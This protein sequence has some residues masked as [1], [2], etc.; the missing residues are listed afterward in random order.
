MEGTISI[1]PPTDTPVLTFSRISG[2]HSSLLIDLNPED[3]LEPEIARARK[4]S[5]SRFEEIPREWTRRYAI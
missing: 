4:G 3:P 5:E 2:V 1:L